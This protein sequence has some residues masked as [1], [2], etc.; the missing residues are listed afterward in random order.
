MNISVKRIRTLMDALL[1]SKL[2]EG[3]SKKDKEQMLGMKIAFV[4]GVEEKLKETLSS[5]KVKVIIKELELKL[6]QILKV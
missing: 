4:R 5:K 6:K 1:G 3:L 2:Y